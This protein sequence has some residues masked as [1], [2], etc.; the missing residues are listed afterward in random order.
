MAHTWRDPRTSASISD[1]R[2]FVPKITKR[3][4]FRTTH[5]MYSNEGFA[6]G[7]NFFR[8]SAARGWMASEPR[9]YALG[10]ISLPLR[11]SPNVGLLAQ[12]KASNHKFWK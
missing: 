12:R 9:A 5:G 11:G 8:R 1:S 2:F 3:T 6:N 4:I 7:V 10:F